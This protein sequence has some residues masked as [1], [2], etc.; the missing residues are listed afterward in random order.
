MRKNILMISAL[1]MLMACGGKKTQTESADAEDSTEVEAKEEIVDLIND[2]YA[3][4]AQNAGDIDGRFACHV[5]RETVAAVE[6]KD[7]HVAEIGFFNDDYW[8]Q[9]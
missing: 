1:L 3:A 9:M 6:E 2:L 7:S 4:E 8:T 5:W